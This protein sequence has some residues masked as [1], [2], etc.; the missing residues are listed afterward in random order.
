MDVPTTTD[1]FVL[2]ALGPDGLIRRTRPLR[3]PGPGEVMVQ[4][5]A[6]SLNYRDLKILRGTYGKRQPALPIVPLSDGA[7]R[8]VAAG[9]EVTAFAPGDRVL[10]IYMEGWHSGPLTP[11]GRATWRSKSGEVDG[12]ATEYAVYD[13]ADVLPIP[14]SLDDFEA[15]CLPCAGVTAW[16]ALVEAGRLKAGDTVLTM[17]TGAVSLFALQI[18]R[19]SGARVIA[20]SSDEGKLAR[21]AALGAWEVVNYRTTPDWGEAVRALTGGRG[22]DVAVEVGGSE[23]IAQ[24]LRATKANGRIASVGNLSGG[25]AHGAPGERGIEIVH[26][27]VGS[28]QM[29]E[30][31]MR[32][33]DMHGVKPVI[34]RRF[35]IGELGEALRTLERGEH[36]GK[37]VLEF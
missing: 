18:A 19:M 33:L 30:D 32:A 35:P 21:L 31:L 36:F 34:D 15:A 3:A 5:R 29:T 10:P 11:E 1:A 12:V 13:A 26:V 27:T 17:G 28:R 24:S 6:A 37:I 7:G 22:V 20:T 9:R 8:V 14:A 16:H 23:T 2:E 4:M 25:F